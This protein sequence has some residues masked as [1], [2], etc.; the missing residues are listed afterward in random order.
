MAYCVSSGAFVGLTVITGV[1]VCTFPS[2][3][4]P[5]LGVGVN[6]GFASGVG[7]GTVVGYIS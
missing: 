4:A 6:V 5:G 7:D 1:G 3:C 2:S